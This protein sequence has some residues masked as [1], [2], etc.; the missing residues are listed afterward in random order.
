MDA[1]YA[2]KLRTFTKNCLSLTRGDVLII[3]KSPRCLLLLVL[4]V[5]FLMFSSSSNF[6]YQSAVSRCSERHL[7][8]YLD[9]ERDDE[10]RIVRHDAADAAT[11][12]PITGNGH[13]MVQPGID[14]DEIR[15]DELSDVELTL[16]LALHV[17]HER[18]VTI[19]QIVN[20]NKGYIMKSICLPVEDAC[21]HISHRFFVHRARTRLIIQTIKSSTFTAGSLPKLT[22][23]LTQ[24]QQLRDQFKIEQQTAK[25]IIYTKQLKK[26]SHVAIAVE[27]IEMRLTLARDVKSATVGQRIVI[28]ANET[29]AGAIELAQKDMEAALAAS[30]GQLV[31]EHQTAWKDLAHTGIHL[32]PADPDPHH[33][34]PNSFYVNATLYSLLSTSVSINS[35]RSIVAESERPKSPLLAPE[36]CYNASPTLHSKSLW[37]CPASIAE[38]IGLRD[39]WRLTLQKHGCSGLV[40][41]GAEGLLQAVVL[42]F[43][44]L[45]FTSEHMALGTDA[46][47]LHNEIGLSNIRYRNNTVDI[48]LRKET[49]TALPEMYVK[50]RQ[51]KKFSEPLYACE[52]GCIQRLDQLSIDEIR[53]PIFLTNPPTPILYISHLKEHLKLL[54]H[55]LH[56]RESLSHQEHYEL[57]SGSLKTFWWCFGLGFIIF[58]VILIRIICKEWGTPATTP[59]QYSYRFRLQP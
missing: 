44:G 23:E 36:Y 57:H 4:Y 10:V 16:D 20:Y 40:N 33:I 53:F 9:L 21:G 45:Q 14:V 8:K 31:D 5:L 51:L 39:T 19:D 47:V 41:E 18:Q 7:A 37:K 11:V 17:K 27:T 29:N 3:F 30:L 13:V 48:Y 34:M 43:A 12:R 15:L 35:E 55:T 28:A 54:Q 49:D 2:K 26:K 42:S 58:H 25:Y 6:Q 1:F 46:E 32:D 59:Q 38:A 52:A 22:V 56:V 50:R 24:A